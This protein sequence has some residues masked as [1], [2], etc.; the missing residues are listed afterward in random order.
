MKRLIIADVLSKRRYGKTVGHYKYLAEL[1]LKMFSPICDVKIAGGPVYGTEFQEGTYIPLPYDSYDDEPLWKRYFNTL[2]NCKRLFDIATDEDVIVMQSSTVSTYMLGIALFAKKKNKIFSIIY[3]VDAVST[4]IK[5]LIYG[6]AKRH[7]SGIITSND[8]I[9]KAYRLPYCIVPDYIF[10]GNINEIANT[11]FNEK[12]YDFVVL[13]GFYPDKG[14][15]EAARALKGKPYKVMIAG[16]PF[17]DN[18][19]D[20]LKSI[21]SDC[22]NITLRL[23]YLSEE[24]YNKYMSEARY[25]LLNYQGSYMTRSSGIVL[26]AM[27]HGVPVVGHQSFPLK[28]AEQYNV[29]YVYDDISHFNPEL[30]LNENTWNYYHENIIKYLRGNMRYKDTL[31]DFLELNDK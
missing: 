19:E 21:S 20:E 2:K 31:A 10:T 6:I 8:V 25:C 22:T 4:K 27:F 30:V 14:V 13:G 24:D 9:A 15:V 12:K 16:R 5:R 28:I 3:E 7:I 26:D 18:M 17:N 29:G 11:T 1:Y 23:G